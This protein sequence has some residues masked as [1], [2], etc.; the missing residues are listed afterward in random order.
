MNA[1]LKPLQKA[2]EETFPHEIV[3]DGVVIG[4]VKQYDS[5]SPGSKYFA[6]ISGVGL[7]SYGSGFGDTQEAAIKAAVEDAIGSAERGLVWAHSIKLG[8][9]GDDLSKASGSEG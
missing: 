6:K 4:E 1:V 5:K 7:G 2:I 9:F 3:L 8:V